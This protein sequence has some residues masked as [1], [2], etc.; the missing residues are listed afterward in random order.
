MN[1]RIPAYQRVYNELCQAIQQKLFVPGES[2]PAE[3]ELAR[4]YDV[5]IGTLRRATE[6]LEREGRLQRRQG[7]GS[8]VTGQPTLQKNVRTA[9]LNHT[10]PAF[11]FGVQQPL[12][13]QSDICRII[14]PDRVCRPLLLGLPTPGQELSP[15]WQQSS[16]VQLPL[17][18]FAQPELQKLL[19]PL[20]EE[21]AAYFPENILRECR[22]LDGTL[23]FLPLV[24]N[25]TV[26]YHWQAGKGIE[27]FSEFTYPQFLDYLRKLKKTQ[28][29]A[30]FGLQPFPGLF[31]ETLLEY[32]ACTDFRGAAFAHVAT[33]LQTLREEDLFWTGFG[34]SITTEEMFQRPYFRCTF[35]G[36]HPLDLLADPTA[37]TITALP[38]KH[39]QASVFGLALPIHAPHYEA[40]LDTLESL[41][42]DPQRLA[43]LSLCAPASLPALELWCRKYPVRGIETFFQELPH[44]QIRNG[45]DYEDNYAWKLIDILRELTFGNISAE[46]AGQL[47]QQLQA[48]CRIDLPALLWQ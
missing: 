30:P 6:Q 23:R 48:S 4:R 38:Q 19:A 25:M 16:L 42:A 21:F 35:I 45:W 18:S 14:F 46:T 20:P 33:F 5:S 27:N 13:A 41:F 47:L 24:A 39:G 7:K 12:F 26:A 29:L 15:G 17:T 37:W 28:H 34:Q 11:S 22:A 43:D 2:L 40:A 1:K 3:P 32:F 31:Y 10:Q 9:S 36:P 44:C 8:F